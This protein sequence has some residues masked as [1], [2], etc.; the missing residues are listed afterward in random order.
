MN[1]ARERRTA[2]TISSHEELMVV[3]EE[4]RA[5]AVALAAAYRRKLDADPPA[6][7]LRRW[8]F[9][10]LA[11]LRAATRSVVKTD[12]SIRKLKRRLTG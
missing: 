11:G 3:L 6:G 1:M 7:R 9:R 10:A 8:Q 5:T 4:V 2:T 12:A